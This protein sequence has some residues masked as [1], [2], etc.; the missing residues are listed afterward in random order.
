MTPEMA[1]EDSNWSPRAASASWAERNGERESDEGSK[2]SDD[3]VKME[4]DHHDEEKEV[5]TPDPLAFKNAKQASASSH[6][7]RNSVK[8]SK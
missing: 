2:K 5:A 8:G 3:T 1:Q 4:D 7:A 6:A